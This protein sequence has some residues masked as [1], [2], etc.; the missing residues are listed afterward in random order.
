MHLSHVC[1]LHPNILLVFLPNTVSL[2]QLLDQGVIANFRMI[3]L[4]QTLICLL[5]VIDKSH[6]S[7]MHEFLQELQQ[8][9]S[10]RDASVSIR[11][12][13]LYIGLSTELRELPCCGRT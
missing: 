4:Q 13:L 1:D 2:L 7:S 6:K 12:R 10:L 8:A 9:I 3:Y 11:D 5:K